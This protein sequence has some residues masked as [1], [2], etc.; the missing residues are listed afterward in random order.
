MSSDAKGGGVVEYIA[1]HQPI[2]AG[3]AVRA[4]WCMAHTAAGLAAAIRRLP[5]Q[6]VDEE[7]LAYSDALAAWCDQAAEVYRDYLAALQTRDEQAA[8]FVML[9]WLS[10]ASQ[11]DDLTRRRNSTL[12]TLAVRHHWE[13]HE[14]TAGN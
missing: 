7:M 8:G 11:S 10:L 2:P 6:D 3:G 14:P 9:K 12:R 1:Q 5:T 13:V 4:A